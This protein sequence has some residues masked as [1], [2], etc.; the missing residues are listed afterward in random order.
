VADAKK[1][2]PLTFR[3]AYAGALGLPLFVMGAV[4]M[5]GPVFQDD[6]G[7]TTSARSGA[8]ED[9]SP[10]SAPS[11]TARVSPST[12][13][14]RKPIVVSTAGPAQP[15]GQ[16]VVGSTSDVRAALDDFH[17]KIAFNALN[18]ALPALE[19]LIEIDPDVAKDAHSDIVDLAQRIM[20]LKGSEPDQ[21][22]EI[23]V[24]KMGTDGID[25]LYE[26]VTTKGGSD[27]AVYSK[28]LLDRPDILARGSPAVQVA[29]KL[30]EAKSCDE[31]RALF[32]DI[33][34]HGDGRSLGQLY[35]IGK[36]RCSRYGGACCLE[37]DKDLDTTIKAVQAKGFQ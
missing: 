29:Y 6:G 8:S 18:Q 11:S 3:L 14:V 20:G 28:K 34:E 15:S 10:S 33:R 24:T 19:H 27:A 26:M 35:L 17:K 23:L 30:R 12:G 22:Y 32:G 31:I 37:N 16:L 1:T 25:I 4:A 9:A 36:R 7:A 21:V 5:R 13:P 2:I